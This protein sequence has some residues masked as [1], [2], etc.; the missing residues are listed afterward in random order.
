MAKQNQEGQ[1]RRADEEVRKNLPRGVK[2]VR[3]LRGHEATIAR[4]A[5]SPDGRILA[6]PS[7]DKTV[8]L[9]DAETG[10]CLRTLHGHREWVITVA[11]DPSGRTLAI[12]G[13]D[14]TIKLWDPASGELLRTLEGHTNQVNSVTFD[15]SGRT[16]AS[17]SR[18]G[19]IKLWDPAS[20]NLLRTL[21]GH[22]H[23]VSRVIFDPSG[24][25]LATG[26]Y[27]GTIKLWDPAS[28]K[29]LDTLKG[30]TSVIWTVTFDPAGG[31]LA[32]G[33]GDKT[34][35]LWDRAS[36][37]LL[38]TLEGHT[39]DVQGLAF[40]PNPLYLASKGSDS[41]RVFN[42]DTG[43]CVSSISEPNSMY[44]TPSLAFHPHLPV[45]AT[46]GSDPGTPKGECDRIIHIYS[47]DLSALLSQF[48][49][50][51]IAYTSAKV[52]LVGDS[53]VGKTG[54]DWRLA[55]GEFKEHASTHGKILAAEPALQAATR[56]RA[57][58]SGLVG[59]RRS[60]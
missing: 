9:W 56:R 40:S 8:R 6:S 16:L 26:I 20:G 58:R 31:T 37:K 17:G 49:A 54:L 38:R 14:H 53:G 48:A 42:I 28:G 39:G 10:E 21:E 41:V 43:A 44:W 18:D 60:G 13:N 34:I 30:Q 12:G 35:L 29:L 51:S 15:P 2:L 7:R 50:P 57:V 3:T 23:G 46:V 59:S 32:G 36:G 25:T 52:V 5:W 24:R 1:W 19:T 27:D 55:H 45:L 22:A 4:I 33:S 11:F 47:L